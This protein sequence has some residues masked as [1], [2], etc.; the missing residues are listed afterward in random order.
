MKNNI[1]PPKLKADMEKLCLFA[2]LLCPFDKKKFDK[3]MKIVDGKLLSS[4]D[5]QEEFTVGL[6]KVYEE[7]SAESFSYSISASYNDDKMRCAVRKTSFRAFL[8]NGTRVVRREQ[9]FL[10]WT[11]RLDTGRLILSMR[12]N[13]RSIV[14]TITSKFNPFARGKSLENEF[15]TMIFGGSYLTFMKSLV[16]M[17]YDVVWIDNVQVQFSLEDIHV[18]RC[19]VKEFMKRRY[20]KVFDP[21]FLCVNN[22]YIPVHFNESELNTISHYVSGEIN[23]VLENS[24]EEKSWGHSVHDWLSRYYQIRYGVADNVSS[25]YI[26]SCGIVKIKPRVHFENK[27]HFDNNHIKLAMKMSARDVVFDIPEFIPTK[28]FSDGVEASIIKDGIE[29]Y[30]EGLEMRH[31]VNTYANKVIMNQS[32]IYK[33]THNGQRI[34]IEIAEVNSLVSDPDKDTEYRLS[35]VSRKANAPDVEATQKIDKWLKK[36]MKNYNPKV[37]GSYV[38]AEPF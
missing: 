15:N 7:A 26:N 29:L 38:L 32:F 21:L 18:T 17:F 31:C 35:Q 3:N 20:K 5:S 14:R 2:R 1:K 36:N 4:D 16:K 27:A 6:K 25:D 8:V 13:K 33:G 30:R 23:K 9:S 12:R 10:S 28:I 34:T 24:K 19:N 22:Y 37:M 11:L